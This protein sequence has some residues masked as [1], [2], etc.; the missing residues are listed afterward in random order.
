MKKTTLL[1]AIL[2][3]FALPALGFLLVPKLSG[4]SSGLIVDWGDAPGF[5]D[6]FVRCSLG[7]LV[8]SA[9]LALI[10][11]RLKAA[12]SSVRV[13]LAEG[14]SLSGVAVVGGVAAQSVGT[15]VPPVLM[16]IDL[17][18]MS[19]LLTLF[20]V[21]TVLLL[22]GSQAKSKAWRV[23]A[24]LPYVL[25]IPALVLTGFRAF[26][27][28]KRPVGRWREG[29]EHQKSAPIGE[30]GTPRRRLLPRGP[31]RRPYARASSSSP[32]VQVAEP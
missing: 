16:L 18:F 26:S 30:Q 17:L 5:C 2:L 3:G 20:A 8:G 22:M 15:D 23:P 27:P 32:T 24:F 28:D 12:R 14:L 29:P 10:G 4:G 7:C 11:I 1:L 9:L 13:L 6:V 19:F 31:R 21:P 25:A